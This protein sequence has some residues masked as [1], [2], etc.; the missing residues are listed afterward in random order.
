[1]AG[2]I[3]ASLMP[4]RELRPGDVVAGK[5]R[6]ER[7]LG[8][9]GMAVVVAARHLQLDE[10]VALKFLR[11]KDFPTQ[12]DVDRFLREARAAVKIK[13]EHVTRVYD[14]GTL[15]DGAPYIVMEYLE[16]E[17]LAALLDRGGAMPV[18]QAVDFV[19]EV[20]EAIAEAHSLG[21]V[22]RDLKPANLFCVER[23][24]GQLAIKV[25]DFGI[26]KV[27]TP[28]AEGHALTQT[29]D[30]MGS[31]LY[32]SPEQMR[33]SKAVDS[34]TD[35]WSLGIILFQLVTGR[36]PFVG[37]RVTELAIK[38]ATETTPRL[39]TFRADAPA[40]L[41]SIVVRCL[42]K[43]RS[44]RFQSV[45]ELAVALASLGSSQAKASVERILGTLR[46][47]GRSRDGVPGSDPRRE[48]GPIS[49]ISATTAPASVP[50][51]DSGSRPG[52]TRGW[53]RAALV[54]SSLAALSGV[55]V[56]LAFL[57]KPGIQGA[58]RDPA[59][60]DARGQ[61]ADVAPPSAS[62]PLAQP[63]PPQAPPIPPVTS[64]ALVP[65]A[66]P[67]ASGTNSAPPR[68]SPK[69]STHPPTRLY[70]P[71]TQA[72]QCDPPY[73]IDA[74]GHHVPKPECL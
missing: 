58:T 57:L 22:H 28:D 34:R 44:A 73:T 13:G 41:E 70:P 37:D 72:P 32:M 16:G 53:K 29:A 21:I 30:L 20:C 59:P 71:R 64:S 33:D 38:I 2:E 36:L 27:I 48:Q 42:E 26:S 68:A 50:W 10:R 54:T 7:V 1:L 39:R 67:A 51:G 3:E 60:L 6:V 23:P 66:P 55:A 62:S 17:D 15:E 35:I 12:G 40:A 49:A 69:P 56:L 46:K 25:L 47:G 43:D 14:V 63:A 19:L 45:G 9:G 5:Y 4:E 65:E 31:P 52:G 11:P 74:R 61:A 18:A 8:A 24:D